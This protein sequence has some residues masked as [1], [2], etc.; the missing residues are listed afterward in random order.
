MQSGKGAFA[1]LGCLALV[2]LHLEAKSA[3]VLP[4]E[5]AMLFVQCSM[6]SGYTI[7]LF[8][9]TVAGNKETKPDIE[10][11]L[12]CHGI[13]PND[14]GQL[15]ARKRRWNSRERAEPRAAHARLPL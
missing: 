10:S 12:S 6:E 15:C 3:L 2:Y 11:S 4:S 5:Q 14:T 7:K 1:T 13:A 8:V 9:Y